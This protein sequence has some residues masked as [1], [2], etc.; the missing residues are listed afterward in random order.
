MKTLLPSPQPQVLACLIIRLALAETFC[1]NCGVLALDEPTANLDHDNMEKFADALSK[2]ACRLMLSI[3]HRYKNN[4]QG[5][6]QKSKL[7]MS[8][9]LRQ[10]LDAFPKFPPSQAF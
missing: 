10:H 9:V 7:L 1:L 8:S 6:P 3:C 4:P 5:R 2:Y